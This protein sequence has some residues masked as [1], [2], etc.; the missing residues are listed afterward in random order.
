MRSIKNASII[1]GVFFV[2][3]FSIIPSVVNSDTVSGSHS[4]SVSAVVQAPQPPEEPKTVV[5]FTGLAYPNSELTLLRNGTFLTNITTNSSA[6]FDIAI[7]MNPGTYTFTIYGEDVNGL[8]GPI[9]N[10][11]VTLNSG[12]TL[13]ITGIFLG[14][15]IE[16]DRTSVKTGETITFSGYTAPNSQVD[17]FISPETVDS[18]SI[19]SNNNG[20]WSLSLIAG[21]DLMNS[22]NHQA[23]SNAT[24]GNGDISEYSKTITFTVTEDVEPNPCELASPADLNCDGH[25]NLVD[26]SILMFYWQ[27]KNPAN[28]RADINKD[29][30][31]NIVDFSIMMFYWTG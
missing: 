18:Y 20:L 27:E 21:E 17:L 23:R 24:S 7:E 25:V 6:E 26:F 4:V 2:L 13:S 3:I 16:A 10:I 14:P 29:D 31:V 19:T 30:I 1:V 28:A 12:V 15:T 22:G 8:A 5:Q 9:F 11:S